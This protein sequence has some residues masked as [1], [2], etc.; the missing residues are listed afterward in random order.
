MRSML[1]K[2]GE[3]RD[4]KRWGSGSQ[5]REPGVSPG[6][7]GG[8]VREG[9]RVVTRWMSSVGET[10]PVPHCTR[11]D[12]GGATWLGCPSRSNEASS[13]VSKSLV[14]TLHWVSIVAALVRIAQN[15]IRM[16]TVAIAAAAAALTKQAY[17]FI[18]LKSTS[19]TVVVMRLWEV[20]IV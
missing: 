11:R 17:H 1:E 6:E 3:A 9:V 19:R 13:A 5:A 10:V 7:E 16:T 2:V 20:S 14:Y 4:Q 12:S 15:V 8:K 18:A